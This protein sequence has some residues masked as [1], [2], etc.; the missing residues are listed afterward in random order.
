MKLILKELSKKMRNIDFTMLTTRTAGGALTSR[1]M[2]NNGEVD[3]DG[4]SWFFTTEDAGMVGD[5]MADPIVGLTLTGERGL[6]GKPGIFIAIEARAELIR[7]KAAFTAH[8]TKGLERWF[9]Q[10]VDT[11]GLVL[12]QAKASRIAYWDGEDEGELA[13]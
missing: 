13:L 9:P 10:G 12:I 3:Y 7:D 4:D 5:I 11:P 8:W 6:L 1:P 2:S